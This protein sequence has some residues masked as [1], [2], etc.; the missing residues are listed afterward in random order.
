[1]NCI[2]A[3][4]TKLNCSAQNC[5]ILQQ[6]KIHCIERCYTT[7]LS[8][9]AQKWPT[10]QK[11]ALHWTGQCP[12]P[13]GHWDAAKVISFAPRAPS[14]DPS[15]PHLGAAPSLIRHCSPFPRVSFVA[16]FIS[17]ILVGWLVGLFVYKPVEKLPCPL[18]PCS[19]F[20]L[21][22]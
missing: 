22:P 6:Q 20:P 19:S 16:L 17:L 21:N 4:C 9:A 2:E 8:S 11:R 14:A 3:W 5:T 12:V 1:M 10:S 18:H 15:G 7:L 13:S